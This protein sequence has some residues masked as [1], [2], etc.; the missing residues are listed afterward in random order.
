LQ[1]RLTGLG[2]VGEHVAVLFPQGVADGHYSASGPRR[3][4]G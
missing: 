1:R 4:E 2:E 3:E